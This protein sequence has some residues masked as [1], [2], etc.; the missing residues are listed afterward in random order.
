MNELM[1]TNAGGGVDQSLSERE[2]QELA[3]HEA[4]IHAWPEARMPAGRGLKAIR[5]GRRHRDTH[6][7]FGAYLAARWGFTRQR[8]HQ[9][10]AAADVITDLSTTVDKV[11]PE[12]HARPLKRLSADDRRI[13]YAAAQKMA[14]NGKVTSANLTLLADIVRDIA[15]GTVDDGTGRE[16][17]W[18]EASSDRKAM[19]IHEQYCQQLEQPQAT[20]KSSTSL[21]WYTARPVVDAVREVL[22]TIDIGP[23]T[24][25]EA[26]RT[27]GADMLDGEALQDDW[28][29]SVF[30]NLPSVNDLAEDCVEHVVAQYDAGI[31]TAV[32]VVA[33]SEAV[34][35]RWFLPLFDH[36]LCFVTEQIDSECP[37]GIG[38]T[39]PRGS[40]IVYLGRDVDRFVRAFRRFGRVMR[41][42]DRESE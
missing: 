20:A 34:W 7:S 11:P 21:D 8:A 5:D 33:G 37:D 1:R 30:L 41:R 40:V 36:T 10:I 35:N 25:E 16:V 27:V 24:C 17:A 18:H 13:V 42:C 19:L 31:A 38:S 22:G 4:A 14:P 28:P 23:A 29:G 15:T 2:R 39:P 12:R 32:V 6:P 3:A 26:N 9:L